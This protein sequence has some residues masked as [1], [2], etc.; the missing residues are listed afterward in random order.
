MKQVLKSLHG[1]V[2]GLA[3]DDSVVA[4]KGL[5]IGDF[6]RQFL[7]SSPSHVAEFDDFTGKTLLGTWGVFK[8]SDAGCA[9]FALAAA[10]SGIAKATTGANAGV[11]MATNG[12][13]INGELNFQANSGNLEFGARVQL[14]AITTV[15]LFVGFTNQSTA[16]AMPVNGAGGGDGFTV[17]ANDCVGFL[18]DTTM[19]D[20]KWWAV[21]VKGGAA[22]AGINSAVAPVA[23]AYDDLF[24][25]VDAAGNASFYLDGA[26]V[27]TING[28]V[29]AT[30]PLCP[31]VAAFRRSAASANLQADYLYAAC[32]RV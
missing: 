10:L 18:F 7:Q 31:V 4:A 26:S 11:S 20:A 17:V 25:Q 23:A 12:V 28:A 32:N 6:P 21:G 1:R 14:A 24:V 29:T 3:D 19:T 27:G 16:L 9:N 2:F 5:R 30:V 13:Q 15:A 22:T 8:G